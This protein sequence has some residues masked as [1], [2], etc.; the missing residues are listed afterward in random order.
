MVT[1]TSE[2]RG[3]AI[4]GLLNAVTIHQTFITSQEIAACPQ[5]NIVI[6][7]QYSDCATDLI[8]WGLVPGK[9]RRVTC[10]PQHLDVKLDPPSFLFN[11]C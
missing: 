7:R 9:G 6:G 3:A 1:V 10:S 2:K 8:I 5:H 4:C 11:G